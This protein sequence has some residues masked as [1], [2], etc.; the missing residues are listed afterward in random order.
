VPFINIQKTTKST[1]DN[2]KGVKIKQELHAFLLSG[3]KIGNLS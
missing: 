3:K 2:E 1:G